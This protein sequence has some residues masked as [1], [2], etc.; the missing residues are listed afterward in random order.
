MATSSPDREVHPGETVLDVQHLSDQTFGD[1]DLERDILVL[2]REQCG[3]L[4]PVILGNCQLPSRVDAAHTLK[5]GARAVG[6]VEVARIADE[7]ETALRRHGE[8]AG[9]Q[10][11]ALSA[12]I[13]E[14]RQA[15]DTRLALA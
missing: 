4:A 8:L 12:S 15:I 6:A 11:A 3:K 7:V 14:V 10:G 2:F 9:S 13:V 5:G 1:A